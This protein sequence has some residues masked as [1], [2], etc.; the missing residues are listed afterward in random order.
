MT[1]RRNIF[2]RDTRF[3]HPQDPSGPSFDPQ[4]PVGIKTCCPKPL[5]RPKEGDFSWFEPGMGVQ[6]PNGSRPTLNG[7]SPENSVTVLPLRRNYK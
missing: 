4:F 7:P 6:N 3:K 5:S 1:L 2:N